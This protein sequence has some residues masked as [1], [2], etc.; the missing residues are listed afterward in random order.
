MKEPPEDL[1]DIGNEIIALLDRLPITDAVGVL[2][3]VK[4]QIFFSLRREDIQ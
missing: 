4:E 3:I 1:V 2:E